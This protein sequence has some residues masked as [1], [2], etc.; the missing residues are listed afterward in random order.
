MYM[1]VRMHVCCMYHYSSC[2]VMGWEYTIDFM[3]AHTNV[4]THTHLNSGVGGKLEDIAFPF[5]QHSMTR[6][7]ASCVHAW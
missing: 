2:D 3:Y 4:Y 6:D 5:I 1:Y 7:R